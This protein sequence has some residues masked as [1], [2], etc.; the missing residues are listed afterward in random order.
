MKDLL[1]LTQIV[2]KRKLKSVELINQPDKGKEQSKIQEFYDLITDGKLQSDEEAAQ[3]LYGSDKLTPSY[4]K[5]RNSLK[6][7][8]INGLFLI[9]LKQA[10]YKDRQKAYY[11]CY[12]DWSAAKILFGKQAR[13]AAISISR[14][15]L[16]IA[17][18]YE[19][20]ELLVDILQ[21]M[22]LYYGTIEGDLKKYEQYNIELKQQQ[23]IWIEEM[24]VES[25]YLDLSVSF[26]NSKGSN[27]GLQERVVQN[28]NEVKKVMNSISSYRLQLCARL[29]EV[30]QFSIVND[31]INTLDVCERAIHFFSNKEYQ[32]TVPLQ[33]FHYQKAIC[34]TQLRRFEEASETAHISLSFIDEGSFNWFKVKEILLLLHMHAGQFDEAFLQ[35]QAVIKHD[36]FTE[37]PDNIRETWLIA[38]AYFEFLRLALKL[39]LPGHR[40]FRWSKFQNEFEVLSKDKKGMNIHLYILEFLLYTLSDERAELFDRA[41]A[42]DKYRLRYLTTEELTRANHFLK[43][44]AQLPKNAFARNQVELKTAEDFDALKALPIELANQAHSVELVPYETLWELILES[45]Q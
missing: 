45:L 22:R 14:K 13:T 20:T 29:I 8:L 23:Q 16:K 38:E 27:T 2:T 34:L 11:E 35:F 21:T 40:P 36:R 37:L 15:L 44:L 43:M 5:L 28:F 24:R 7:R 31:Y 32:A 25:L 6:N 42:L 19:F 17:R 3:L 33:V 41:E 39:N 26:V 4:Q 12:R 18:Q 9:D 1:E 10:S 30:S